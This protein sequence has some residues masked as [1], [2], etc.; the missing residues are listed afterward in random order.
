[1][2]LPANLEQQQPTPPTTPP[3]TPMAPAPRDD[4]NE[5]ALRCISAM[6]SD[7][8][9]HPCHDYLKQ[10]SSAAKSPASRRGAIDARCRAD[11][12]RWMFRTVANLR[13]RRETAVI[14]VSNLD[15]YLCMSR[16]ARLDRKEYQRG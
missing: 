12:V 10:A 7:E 4:E 3:P 11:V 5:V 1:M 13:M 6:L 16:R 14:A 2:S 15:R 8:D 9:L